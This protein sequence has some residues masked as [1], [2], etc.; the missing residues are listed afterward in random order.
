MFYSLLVQ[1]VAVVVSFAEEICLLQGGVDKLQDSEPPTPL[2]VMK[3]G[4]K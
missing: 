3:M 2:S 4:S 1:S